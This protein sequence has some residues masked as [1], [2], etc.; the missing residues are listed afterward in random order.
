MTKYKKE[1]ALSICIT[2]IVGAIM[3][4]VTLHS[5]WVTIPFLLCVITDFKLEDGYVTNLII[6]AIALNVVA[7]YTNVWFGLLF[8]AACVL[9]MFGIVNSYNDNYCTDCIIGIV[10]F[11]IGAVICH[12]WS[13][14]LCILPSL[15]AIFIVLLVGGHVGR[16][17]RKRNAKLEKEREIQEQKRQQQEYRKKYVT[18]DM[19]RIEQILVG[20]PLKIDE[21]NKFNNQLQSIVNEYEEKAIQR[22]EDVYKSVKG[23]I[24]IPRKNYFRKFDQLSQQ[25]SST[26]NQDV[27]LACAKAVKETSTLVQQKQDIINKNNADIAKYNQLIQKLQKQYD[28]ELSLQKIKELNRDV[29]SQMEN[30]SDDIENKE[31]KNFEI[32]S[33]ISDIDLLDKE[34]NERRQYEIQF[35]QIEI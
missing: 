21:L 12:E 11:D 13:I 17:L 19:E 7:F 10:L 6:F 25:Y 28:D 24:L 22:I 8:F 14:W 23:K 34:V 2:I 29:N 35:G 5:L 30:I 18:E 3:A 4:F 15:I 1:K 27:V 33:I 9:L 32:Q 16:F 20:I 31:R 26:L